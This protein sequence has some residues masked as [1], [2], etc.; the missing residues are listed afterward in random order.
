MVAEVPTAAQCADL[1]LAASR[2]D[3]VPDPLLLPSATPATG[4]PVAGVA[5][6][7]ERGTT[8]LPD[9]YGVLAGEA[10]DVYWPLGGDGPVVGVEASPP[11]A[12]D[13]D[14]VLAGLLPQWRPASAWTTTTSGVTA[15]GWRFVT[16]QRDLAR[17][18]GYLTALA[19]VLAGGDARRVLWALGNPARTVLD[20]GAVV[21]VL[22]A[23]PVLGGFDPAVLVGTWRCTTG[24]G[25]LQHRFG[26]DGTVE[27]G[28]GAVVTLGPG[29]WTSAGV[30]RGTYKVADG[31]LVLA[32]ADAGVHYLAR[33]YDEWGYGAQTPVR[34]LGLMPET[35]GDEVDHALVQE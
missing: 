14:A 1:L 17:G 19:A 29:E 16:L 33:V 31:A 2:P 26:A 25:V 4:I 3:G 32:Y 22:H 23:Q 34:T 10:G 6:G 35:G 20:G 28:T 15:G 18:D 27:S 8:G 9:G 7:G 11:A 21:R 5:L 12:D 30:R 24:V 13:P